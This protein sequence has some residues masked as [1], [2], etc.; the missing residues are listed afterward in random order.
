MS[1][2]IINDMTLRDGMHP[3]AIKL[4][5]SKWLRLQLL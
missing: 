5:L 1:K 3:C 4:H 2:I